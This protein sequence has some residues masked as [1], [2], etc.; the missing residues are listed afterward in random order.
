MTDE[1]EDRLQ[2]F[3]STL[4]TLK[5]A[6]KDVREAEPTVFALAEEL[7]RDIQQLNDKL[8]KLEEALSKATGSLL[9]AVR[10]I[11]K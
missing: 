1:R 4:N 8:R 9:D 11:N 2:K 6:H 3:D 5:F 7:H 10:I